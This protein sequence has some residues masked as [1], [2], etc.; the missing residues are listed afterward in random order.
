MSKYLGKVEKSCHQ[1]GEEGATFQPMKYPWKLSNQL[2][3]RPG[4]G[5]DMMIWIFVFRMFKYLYTRFVKFS[6][7]IMFSSLALSLMKGSIW[8]L[9]RNINL[10]S[11]IIIP[12][13]H[14][15]KQL[16]SGKQKHLD[17]W[18]YTFL[19]KVFVVYPWVKNLLD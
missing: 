19:F 8:G 17:I 13:Q 14:L 18:K 3:N 11:A 2:S 12:L 7:P 1:A 16:P 4:N 15:V 6:S 5:L 9:R 10:V